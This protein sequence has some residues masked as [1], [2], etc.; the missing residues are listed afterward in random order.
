MVSVLPAL[1]EPDE[2]DVRQLQFK[3]LKRLPSDV[4]QLWLKACLEELDVLMERKVF[5]FMRLPA[6]SKMIKSRW[7]FDVKSDGRKK[8]RLVA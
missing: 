7:V 6:G 4:R 2:K 5:K 1:G 8:A 3:D